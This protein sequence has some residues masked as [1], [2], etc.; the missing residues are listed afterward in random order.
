MIDRDA[1][2]FLV[3]LSAVY[4]RVI[5]QLMSTQ[6][7]LNTIAEPRNRGIDSLI[8]PTQYSASIIHLLGSWWYSKQSSVVHLRLWRVSS[9]H[10]DWQATS[11]QARHGGLLSRHV[12]NKNLTAGAEVA[13]ASPIMLHTREAWVLYRRRSLWSSSHPSARYSCK[14]SI[15][16]QSCIQTH[17]SQNN[18]QQLHGVQDNNAGSIVLSKCRGSGCYLHGCCSIGVT[19]IDT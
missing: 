13:A 8:L 15:V 1:P 2:R 14:S 7:H 3:Y 16:A 19:K 10:I 18:Q 9:T 11:C 12:F 4:Y 6:W 5:T 17:S